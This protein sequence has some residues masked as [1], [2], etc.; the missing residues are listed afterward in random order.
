MLELLCLVAS[1]EEQM[2]KNKKDKITW[3]ITVGIFKNMLY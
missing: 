3:K 2:K 1:F